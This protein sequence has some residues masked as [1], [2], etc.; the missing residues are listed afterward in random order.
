MTEERDTPIYLTA[1]GRRRLEQRLA[2]YRADVARRSSPDAGQPEEGDR[3]DA[4]VQLAEADDRDLVQGLVERTRDVL[5]RA[6]P[7][8]EGPDDGVVRLGSAV[9]L[10]DVDGIESRLLVVHG[11]E[12]DGESSQV[13]ADSPVGQAL[14]GGRAGDQVA[15]TTPA[16][17][18]RLT[19]LAVEPYRQRAGPPG[20]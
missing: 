1:A 4:A 15:V 16:G 3:G 19:L 14:L 12:F 5:A 20:A 18:R 11:A 8:P 10:R 7:M 17:E 13:A 6:L 2:D 9:R